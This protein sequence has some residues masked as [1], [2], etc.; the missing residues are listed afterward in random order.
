MIAGIESELTPYKANYRRGYSPLTELWWNSLLTGSRDI[1]VQ[2]TQTEVTELLATVNET[3]GSDVPQSEPEE[4]RSGQ[5]GLGLRLEPPEDNE[6]IWRLTFW[7]ENK[8]E[9]DFWIP[10]KSIWSSKEREFTLWGKRYRNIQQQ[11]LIAL[12]RAAKVSP[13]IQRSC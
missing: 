6:E 4:A 7:A 8:E 11:L 2:G 1:P 5:L 9:G 10:A 13:D 12:G 3:A